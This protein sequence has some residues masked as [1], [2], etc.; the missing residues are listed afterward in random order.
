MDKRNERVVGYE[1]DVKMQRK[2][3]ELPWVTELYPLRIDEEHSVD[4]Q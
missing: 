4:Q 1:W 2:R 3:K